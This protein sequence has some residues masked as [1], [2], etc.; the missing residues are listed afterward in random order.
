[1]A[2]LTA[3]TESPRT[4]TEA[5]DP[6]R[7]SYR[8]RHLLWYVA[9]TLVALIMI[10][11]LLWMISSSLMPESMIFTDQSLWPSKASFDNYVSGWTETGESFSVYLINSALIAAISIVG[12]LL[13]C[14]LVG[15]AFARLSFPGRRLW[16]ALM[17]GTVMLP[18]HVTLVPQ[19]IL[20]VKLGWAD[21]M[22]P[23]TVPKFFAVDAFFI[24]LMVQF[25]RGIPRDIDA[26]AMLDG[27]G[28]W[29]IYRHI[30][31]PQIRP[32][33]VT[34]AIFT[35]IWSWNDFFTQLLYLSTPSRQTVSLGLQTFL[36]D[37]DQHWGAMFAMTTI[38]LLPVLI[39]FVTFQKLIVEGANIGGLKG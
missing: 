5:P 14:S 21:T 11:P 37:T 10:Y 6:G 7:R 38:S 19:Y 3:T 35:F 4:E 17:L 27:A 15:Y 26:A 2:T 20:F 23:L 31:L 36:G 32:A 1:M 33:L 13:S 28:P 25:M 9:L 24:F 30:V 39:V 12:N 34:A 22:A 18:S 8:R 16:F 29:R